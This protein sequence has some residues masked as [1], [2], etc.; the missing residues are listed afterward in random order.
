MRIKW[1]INKQTAPDEIFLWDW[2]PVTAIEAVVA[3][4]AQGKIAVPGHRVR[5]IGLR[6]MQLAQRVPAIWRFC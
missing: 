4:I 2:S 3:V 6:Q 1:P 5:S